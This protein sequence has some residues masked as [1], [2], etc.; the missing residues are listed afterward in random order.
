MEILPN[1]YFTDFYRRNGNFSKYTEVISGQVVGL[2]QTLEVATSNSSNITVLKSRQR[3]QVSTISDS[4]PNKSCCDRR[5][6]A[7]TKTEGASRENHVTT[8]F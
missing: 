3:T 8:L 6:F 2:R 1:L 7:K 4:K 5:K